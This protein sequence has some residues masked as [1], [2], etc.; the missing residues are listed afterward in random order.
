MT[1]STEVLSADAVTLRYPRTIAGGHLL[2]NL[3]CG[4]DESS[5]GGFIALDDVS[6]VVRRGEAVAV[7]GR[8]GSGKTSLLEILAGTRR[9]TRGKVTRAGSVAALLSLGA[10][11]HP[12]H[13]GRD[14]AELFAAFL[15]LS[16]D[17]VKQRFAGLLDFSGLGD[18][19]DKPMRTYSSG[20]WLRLAFSVATLMNPDVLLV[21]ELLA[22][23]D[24][25]FQ[26]R[27]VEMLRK[28]LRSERMA[29][30]FATHDLQLV[31]SIATRA[32]VVEKGQ[33]V[34][35][36]QPDNAIEAYLAVIYGQK[37]AGKMGESETH[38]SAGGAERESC[39]ARSAWRLV[40]KAHTIGKC[41]LCIKRGV[42][43][44]TSGP[45]PAC[46]ATGDQIAFELVV[47]SVRPMR[48]ALFGYLVRDRLC[49][50]DDLPVRVGTLLADKDRHRR[51]C[52]IP[53]TAQRAA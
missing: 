51:A 18:F 45:F 20:M 1:G 5:G 9:P 42:V 14:N 8:N 12:D 22:V 25:E 44:T 35:E 4:R 24:I 19:I 27:C 3:L 7:L 43:S 52:L 16:P 38:A 34:F 31:S 40:E 13:T 53:R 49:D 29:V 26:Q 28:R 23:G 33:L 32:L 17:Q 47:Q 46:V 41:E 36:G 10:G 37:A 21:D 50:V 6:L 30:L 39:I 2:W 15:G 11:F 48:Q